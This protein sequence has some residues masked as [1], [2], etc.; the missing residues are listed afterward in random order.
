MKKFVGA[1]EDSLV[2]FDYTYGPCF[3]QG[4]TDFYL[5]GDLNN[6]TTVNHSFLTKLELTNGEGPNCKVNEFEVYKVL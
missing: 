3:G 5:G 6:G 4:G 2:Y 1:K